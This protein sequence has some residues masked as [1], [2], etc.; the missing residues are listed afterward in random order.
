MALNGTGAFSPLSPEYP[1]ITG[2]TI[3][4]T[5]MNAIL[6]DLAV[7]LST[8]LYADGQ[9]LATAD[10]DMNNHKI[11]QLTTGTLAGDATNVLQ[12]FTSPTFTDATVAGT[13]FDI[14]ATG[15]ITVGGTTLTVD[16]T[17][18]DLTGTIVNVA[19]QAPG[20]NTTL[21]ASTAFVAA[22]A[23]SASVP[24]QT[25]NAGKLVNTDGTNAS[26]D[27]KINS[28]V[29]RLADGT[30]VTKLVAFDVSGI[31]TGTT[32]TITQPDASYTPVGTTL[33]QTITNKTITIAD[34]AFTVQD[35]S[36]ATK[37]AV[38]QL[39]GITTGN[40]RTITLEDNDITL[41]TPNRKWLAT[42]TI[43]NDA[44]LDI[45]TELDGTYD[46]YLIQVSGLKPSTDA[47]IL[48]LRGKFAGAYVSATNDYS[49]YTQISTSNSS[50]FT[51]VASGT[52]GSSYV[53]L[54][55]NLGNASGERA[56]FDILLKDITSTDP[57]L[58]KCIGTGRDN[59]GYTIQMDSSFSFN[60]TTPLQGIRL[61]MDLGN[62]STGEV[63]VYGLR[64]TL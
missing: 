15:D 58:G 45:E 62:L 8:A 64:S 12:V 3:L 22:A 38:L 46:T 20:N 13:T 60:K 36:D 52:S 39:S 63:R 50:S 31:T 11:L 44:A 37:Q 32:R 2:T 35:N 9:A 24:A 61:L 47:R 4:A 59:N 27:S 16:T 51:A 25:G 57:K 10:I 19:T 56:D 18:T 14:T 55:A 6:E 49:Y 7:A 41:D 53:Y 21:V 29:V 33:T 17:N 54:G 26:W 42:Y 23:F 1:F 5:D 34:N 28:S 48:Y 30:D 40:T 43:S